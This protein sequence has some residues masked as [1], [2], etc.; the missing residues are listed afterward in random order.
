MARAGTGEVQMLKKL[1]AKEYEF[2]RDSCTDT[3]LDTLRNLERD[4][5][6]AS[7]KCAYGWLINKD[8]DD[9]RKAMAYEGSREILARLIWA[10]GGESEA[11]GFKPTVYIDA[12]FDPPS[13]SQ[14]TND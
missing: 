11:N 3:I 7:Q 1:Q 4:A 12:D 5:L 9:F 13:Q 14:I 8:E 10:F 2:S 6:A